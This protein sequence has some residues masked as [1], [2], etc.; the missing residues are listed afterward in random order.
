MG[1]ELRGQRQ[2]H[3]TTSIAEAADLLAEHDAVLISGG[4]SLMP[5]L[6]QGMIDRDHIVDISNIDGYDEITITQDGLHLGGLATHRDLVT[7]GLTDTPY[8]ALVETAKEIGDRQVRNWGTIGGSVAHAD[9][10]LD[11]PPTLLV[12][13]AVVEY[14]D[15]ETEHEIPISEFCLGQYVTV[16]EEHEIVTGVHVPALPSPS[17]VAFEKFAWRRGDMSLVNAAARL[18][19]DGTTIEAARLVVGAVAPTPLRLED[20][21]ADLEGG[22]ATDDD[23]F[24]SVADRVPE[25]TEPV[26]EAH[27]SVDYKNRTAVNLTR[28]V[29]GKAADRALA[30]GTGTTGDHA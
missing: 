28:K 26:P 9:P 29:L 2:F 14:T 24:E 30:D 7:A 1:T 18:S 25:Y 22:A 13:D 21:E 3:R 23:L 20:L 5:L 27:A 17:G 10:S 4:Q 19:L 6:R 8:R 16:L 11:Y 15:G 12:M